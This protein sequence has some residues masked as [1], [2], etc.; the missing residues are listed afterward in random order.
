MNKLVI[1]SLLLLSA[2]SSFAQ[3]GK[4]TRRQVAPIG[5]ENLNEG[6]MAANF[7][8]VEKAMRSV[9]KLA[10]SKQAQKPVSSAAL[11]K[12]TSVIT[13]FNSLFELCKP[14]FVLTPI[15]QTFD[16]NRF[17]L[18]AS[19]PQRKTLEKLVRWGFIGRTDPIVTAKKETLTLNEFGNLLGLFV[20]RT[21]ELTHKP[22]TT[23]SPYLTKDGR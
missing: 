4:L 21:A 16:A 9:L 8:K 11:A 5:N 18:P 3:E 23:W 17:S 15:D 1:G 22:S 12:R 10:P 7:D 19:S 14:K 20:A 6:E 2:A 13:R